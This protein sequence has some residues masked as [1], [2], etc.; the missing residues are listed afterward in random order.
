MYFDVFINHKIINNT[1]NVEKNNNLFSKK[2]INNIKFLKKKCKK[3]REKPK[4]AFSTYHNNM[5]TKKEIKKILVY[6]S[7]NKQESIK[8]YQKTATNL[9]NKVSNKYYIIM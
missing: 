9:H 6:F 5:F 4:N 8:G 1:N 3:K 2:E 7:K